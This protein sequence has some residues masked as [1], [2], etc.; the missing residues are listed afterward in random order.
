[1]FCFSLWVGFDA[2]NNSGPRSILFSEGKNVVCLRSTHSHCCRVQALSPVWL[3]VIPW[4][5][6]CQ[7]SLSFTVSQNLFRLM[8]IE[9]V[10]LSN[11]FI[12]CRP[13]LLLPS[14][15]S[16][17][18]V[19]YSESA[20]HIRWPKYWSFSFSISPSSEHSG[21]IFFRTDWFDLL[22]VQGT[23]ETLLQYHSLKASI[24]QHSAFFMV[25]ILDKPKCNF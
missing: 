23:P 25:V 8:S 21:L 2:L 3:F 24:L 16:S 13:L 4:A 9:S 15:F 5:A 12:L 20:F 10:M 7:V 17:I 19:F 6:A 18:R 1:M 22:S 14:I 11:H